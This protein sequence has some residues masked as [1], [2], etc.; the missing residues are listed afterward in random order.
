MRALLL[1]SGANPDVGRLGGTTLLAFFA[2]F[3]DRRMVDFLLA[4][5]A[6]PEARIRGGATVREIL[7]GPDDRW[8]PIERPDAPEWRARNAQTVLRISES[9]RL[10][11]EAYVAQNRTILVWDL[12]ALTYDDPRLGDWARAVAAILASPAA[13]GE[14]YRLYL[15]GETLH[16]ALRSSARVRRR[17]ERESHRERRAEEFAAIHFPAR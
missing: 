5:G 6:D 8:N 17:A 2:L 3:G 10:S 15:T 16:E 14:A 7:D 11:P 4:H 1:G 9:L 12:H 13:Q